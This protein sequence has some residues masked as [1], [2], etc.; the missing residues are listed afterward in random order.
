M[1]DE[2]SRPSKKRMRDLTEKELLYKKRLMK[3]TGNDGPGAAAARLT[4]RQIENG[5]EDDNAAGLEQLRR[6]RELM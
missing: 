5:V 4:P 2:R 3:W 6:Y 1:I